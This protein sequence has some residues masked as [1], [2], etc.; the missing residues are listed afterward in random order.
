MGTRHGLSLEGI[1]FIHG[2]ALRWRV[3][4]QT[5]DLIVTHFF[6]DCFRPSEIEELVASFAQAARANAV[7]LLAD[8]Q[9]P[10]AGLF[11]MRAQLIHWIMYRFFRIVTALP[12]RRLTPPDPLLRAANFALR[13]RRVSEGGLLH[14]DLWQRGGV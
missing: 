5:F 10:A 13:E 6:L 7:W 9:I 4:R 11:R 2:D 12:A 14:S 8:F 3:P 1:E